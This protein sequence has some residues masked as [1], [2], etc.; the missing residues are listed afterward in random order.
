MHNLYIYTSNYQE[1][2]A[3]KLAKELAED[4]APPLS[5]E[6]VLVQSKGMERY[7]SMF[8]AKHIG[9]AANI[10]YPF[11]VAFFYEIARKVIPDLPEGYPLSP[12]RLT[13]KLLAILPGNLQDPD[14]LSLKNYLQDPADQVKAYQLSRRISV[15]LDQYVIFRPQMIR[16]WEQGKCGHFSGQTAEMERWQAKIWGMLNSEQ[17]PSHRAALKE[18]FIDILLKQGEELDL[19]SRINLF[20]IASLPPLYLDLLHA[21]SRYVRVNIFFCS[22]SMHYYGDLID[23]RQKSR[24][25]R[26]GKDISAI[27]DLDEG[28]PLLSSL[29]KLGKNFLFNLYEM[30]LPLQELDF[31]SEPER[32][33]LLGCLQNDIFNL[34]ESPGSESKTTILRSDRSIRVHSCHGPMR[35]ME[36]LQDQILNILDQE[37]ELNPEDIVVMIPDIDEYATYIHAIFGNP[38]NKDIQLPFSIADHSLVQ[39]NPVLKVLTSLFELRQTR[40]S[41]QDVISV[42]ED[43]TVYTA[44]GLTPSDVGIVKSWVAETRITWGRD[45]S[46][47]AALGLPETDL[48]TWHTGINRILLGY[49]MDS[50]EQELFQGILPY[51]DIQNSQAELLNTF[52]DFLEFLFRAVEDLNQSKTPGDWYQTVMDILDKFSSERDDTIIH[53]NELENSMLELQEEAYSTGCEN[54]LLKPEVF[55]DMLQQKLTDKSAGRGFLASGITFC[56]M[57]PMRAIPFEVVCLAGLNDGKFPR[58][59]KQPSFNLMAASPKPGDRSLRLDDRYLFLESLLSARKYL[60]ITYTGRSLVDNSSIP[61]S[62]V[63]SELLDCL[64]NGYQGEETDIFEQIVIQHPLHPFSLAYF[65]NHPELFTYSRENFLG[66]RNPVQN[67]PLPVFASEQIPAGESRQNVDIR[68]L[69]KFLKDPVRYFCQER[70]KIYLEHQEEDI[71]ET[72]PLEAIYGLEE[73]QVKQT[74]L[75]FKQKGGTESDKDLLLAMGRIPPGSFGDIVY[76]QTSRE[77]D[78]IW[79]TVNQIHGGPP[80]F[81][82]KSLSIDIQ[83]INLTGQISSLTGKGLL[84]FRPGKIKSKDLLGIWTE[85]LFLC[86]SQKTNC[87]GTT[88][89]LVG[90]DKTIRIDSP[91]NPRM[92]LQSLLQVMQ[93]G[94][95]TVIPFFTSCAEI[96]AREILSRD[97]SEQEALKS[98]NKDWRGNMYQ[99]GV[100]EDPYVKLCFGRE[101]PEIPYKERFAELAVEVFRPVIQRTEDR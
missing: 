47:R 28:H 56:S 75:D 99:P 89:T 50:N 59:D 43:E 36:V 61:P 20:G 91:E 98:A 25:L 96:Y 22:P 24:L 39:G 88:A 4:P 100:R 85:L 1:I 84:S 95:T 101:L 53:K 48:G 33:S 44:L 7:L 58:Q 8:L 86:C 2:L 77:A 40:L 9:V 10:E 46:Q 62:V 16:D 51:S 92:H 34:Q 13:W 29:G 5:P 78:H 21:L 12:A 32:S 27:D 31:Y 35:E 67:Q 14:L 23:R 11:P 79:Q 42:L 68:D 82:S 94:L 81:Y 38:E 72:E 19:P 26:S 71:Q 64:H 87:P 15:L 90:S 57:L 3:G 93:D 30:D 69:S 49:A 17:F 73:Y 97:K 63:V 18:Q 37:P 54:L 55:F 74:L 83:G 76:S 60:Q 6:T 52:L 65:Q 45:A 41:A 66:A 70:L 80:E